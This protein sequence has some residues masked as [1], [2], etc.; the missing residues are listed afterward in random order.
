V[1]RLQEQNNEEILLEL[2]EAVTKSDKDREKNTRYLNGR[3][4]VNKLHHS[5][6]FYKSCLACII[7]QAVVFGI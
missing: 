4:N 1:K 6:S 2:A 7:T 3:S 5:I